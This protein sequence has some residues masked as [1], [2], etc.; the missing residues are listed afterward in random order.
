M[1]VMLKQVDLRHI[2]SRGT[3]SEGLWDVYFWVDDVEALHAEFVGRGARI[4]YG[5]CTRSYGCREFGVRDIDGHGI[6]FGQVV[7]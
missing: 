2:V 5:L 7:V 1:Y 3:V 6:G 4:D